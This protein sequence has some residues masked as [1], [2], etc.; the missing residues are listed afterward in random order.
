[1]PES[2]PQAPSPQFIPPSGAEVQN[3]NINQT[4][5]F[6]VA[7]STERERIL[8]SVTRSTKIKS[9]TTSVIQTR[10]QLVQYLRQNGLDLWTSAVEFQNSHD[11]ILSSYVIYPKHNNFKE[12]LQAFIDR[13]PNLKPV[14]IAIRDQLKPA[15]QSMQVVS[16]RPF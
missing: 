15:G 3:G 13:Y 1:M 2:I 14:A 12:P 10:A 9:A 5:N 4:A 7:P 6:N 16:P 11:F 8:R